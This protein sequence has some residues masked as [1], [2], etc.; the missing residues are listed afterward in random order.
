MTLND[1]K[2]DTAWKN[3]LTLLVR[4]G[5]EGELEEGDGEPG[6]SLV[7]YEVPLPDPAFVRWEVTEGGEVSICFRQT[8]ISFG[9]SDEDYHWTYHPADCYSG[10]EELDALGQE[11][12]AIVSNGQAVVSG[13]EP[14][15][16]LEL[17]VATLAK[18]LN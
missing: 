4:Y 16:R 8:S 2:F 13:L 10:D 12:D 3:L 14:D 6:S 15:G 5:V 7:A 18:H 17:F 9:K 11:L 1:Y